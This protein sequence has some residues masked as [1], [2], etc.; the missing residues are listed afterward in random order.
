[1]RKTTVRNGMRFVAT[2]LILI[3]ISSF[4]HVQVSEILSLSLS[5]ENRL[6]SLGIFWAAAI[7]VYGV[8]LITIGLLLSPLKND[9]KIR[10]TPLFI[11]ISLMVCL[12]F[13]LLS[14]AIERPFR[15]EQRRLRPGETIN[16]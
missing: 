2:A 5:A 4:Y 7:G 16:I 14:A 8:L 10:L 3:I 9:F 6:Y 12:F 1:M 13:Y 15:D 11:G